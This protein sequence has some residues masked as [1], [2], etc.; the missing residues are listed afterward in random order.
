MFK[1]FSVEE[2]VSSTSQVK[3]S[4]QRSIQAH[5]ISQYPLLEPM[6]DEVLPKKL[7]VIARCHDHIQLII[8]NRQVLFFNQ[9]D[10]PFFPTL[11]FYHKYPTMMTRMQVDKGA[12]RF[13]LGGANLMCPGFTSPGGHVPDDIPVGTPVAIYAEGKQNAL[14]IG[15][16]MMSSDDMFV[17]AVVYI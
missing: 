6:I 9:R 11:K 12:I 17:I 14:A 8:V 1:R 2:N 10:S 5:I 16:T 4:V 7:M 13:V 3:N 15:L